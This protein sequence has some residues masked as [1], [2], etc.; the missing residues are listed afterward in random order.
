MT[1][2]VETIQGQGI[3][4]TIYVL[5][6]AALNISFFGSLAVWV[7]RTRNPFATAFG[8]FLSHLVVG[9]IA[10][11][12]LLSVYGDERFVLSMALWLIDLPILWLFDWLFEMRSPTK[13][14]F[15]YLMV[16][17]AA[18]AVLGFICG[19]LAWLERLHRKGRTTQ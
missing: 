9:M 4:H 7:A 3:A 6:V 1:S 10:L 8:F 11:P 12:L 16:G 18:Y 17:G 13:V 15:L 5:C 19:S 2:F 14:A